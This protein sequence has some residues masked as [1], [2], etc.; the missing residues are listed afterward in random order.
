V[1]FQDPQ[2]NLIEMAHDANSG[3]N[4]G[5]FSVPKAMP[6]TSLAVTNTQSYGLHVYYGGSDGT[7]LE[8]VHLSN[9]GWYDGKFD[10]RSIPG[11]R[12]A[13]INWGTGSAVNIRVYLQQ[14]TG[15]DPSAVSEYAF[16]DDKWILS[17]AAIPPT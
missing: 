13:A 1:Y 14:G 4:R 16:A 17:Q 9:T 11:G 10:Q 8:K 6:R 3:W 2:N 5:T 15:T 12:V 7:I